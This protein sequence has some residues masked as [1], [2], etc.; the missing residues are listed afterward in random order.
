MGN[1][2]KENNIRIVSSSY[3]CSACGACGVVCPKE[4]ISFSTSSV[5][6]LYADVSNDCIDCGLCMKVCP[7]LVN[8]SHETNDPYL[9]NLLKVYTGKSLVHSYYM[10]G[11]SGGICTTLLSYLFDVSEIDAAIV[12]KPSSSQAIIVEDKDDLKSTQGSCYTPVDLLTALKNIGTKKSVAIVGLPC[13]LQGLQ[14]LQKLSKRFECIRYKIGLICDRVLCSGIQDVMLS[15]YPNPTVGHIYWRKKN[16]NGYDYNSAPIVVK[17]ENGREYVIP[18]TFRYALKDMYTPPRCR[19]C[20][21]KLNITADIV[22]GDPWRM[23]NVDFVNGENLIIARTALGLEL[24]EKAESDNQIA[25]TSRSFQ[26]LIDSQL[27]EERKKQVSLYSK[28]VK[29]NLPKIDSHL[30]WDNYGVSSFELDNF[31]NAEN[32]IK[33]FVSLETMKQTE[34]VKRGKRKLWPLQFREMIKNNVIV[35]FLKNK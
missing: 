26:E 5:G 20:S 25:I 15:L 30:L 34:V 32:I 7:S 4:A 17:Y 14:N 28:V 2:K 24:L 12:C 13:H 35:R 18:N 31:K 21:D 16:Y 9:G 23:S 8:S 27:V 19:V 22:L 1:S 33:R 11:Q 10:N 6:R 29:E 3:L